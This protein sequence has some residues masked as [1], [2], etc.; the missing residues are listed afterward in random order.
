MFDCNQDG[1][2]VVCDIL[3]FI[4]VDAFLIS[5]IQLLLEVKEQSFAVPPIILLFSKLLN[6]S[7]LVF[8]TNEQSAAFHPHIIK[9]NMMLNTE[10]YILPKEQVFS[11]AHMTVET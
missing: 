10:V 5:W 7:I 2:C 4:R 11:L 6:L 3:I 1:S 8:R 9:T